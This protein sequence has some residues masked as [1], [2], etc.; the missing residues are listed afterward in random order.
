MEWHIYTLT[1]PRTPDVVRY[2]GVTNEPERRAREH[3]TRVLRGEDATHCGLWKR[4]LIQEGVLPVMRVIE[5]GVGE[6]WEEAEVKWVLHYR[7]LPG[8]RLCNLTDGGKGTRGHKCSEKTRQR[9]REVHLGMKASSEARENMSRAQLGK[10]I[11]SE[12]KEKMSQSHQ[13]VPKSASHRARIGEA[14]R[15]NLNGL[16]RRDSEEVRARRRASV[17]AA[18]VRR[19]ASQSEGE[20]N[21]RQS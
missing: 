5:S 2:V 12:T 19:K 18:W 20:K 16:G 7:S 21:A 15:G 4:K 10:R 1:D 14:L 9:L 6:G 8:H 3:V 11:S 17:K 13:G